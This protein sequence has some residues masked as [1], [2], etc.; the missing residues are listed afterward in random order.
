LKEREMSKTKWT[1]GPWCVDIDGIV[2]AGNEPIKIASA[3]RE[4]AWCGEDGDEESIANGCLFAAAPE[5]Y[6]VVA[7]LIKY[8]D[9]DE[10]KVNGA[11]MWERLILAAKAAT[12]KARGD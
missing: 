3:W 6:D 4:E 1:A 2:C 12:S 11:E 9:H 8:D 10:D 5:L 7:L